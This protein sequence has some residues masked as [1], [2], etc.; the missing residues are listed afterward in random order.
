MGG[1]RLL[2]R[3]GRRDTD[4]PEFVPAVRSKQG[5]VETMENREVAAGMGSSGI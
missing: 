4:E 5:E 2:Q 1:E 3:C